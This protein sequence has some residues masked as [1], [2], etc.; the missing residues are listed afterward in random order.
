MTD[1]AQFNHVP[2]TA[3]KLVDQIGQGVIRLPDLQRPFVWSNAKVRDLIDSMYKGFPVGELMFWEHDDET[4]AHGIGGDTKEHSVRYQV[5]DGQQRLTSLYAAFTGAKVV[6]DEYEPEAVVIS[7]NPLSEEG[8]RFRVS[9]SA[10]KRSPEWLQDIRDVWAD[11]I[12]ARRKYLERLAQARGV[13]HLEYAEADKIELAIN[14]LDQIKQYPFQVIQLQETV[15]RETATD[16]FVRIN[17]QGATLSSSDLIL[18]WLSVYWEE[19]RDRLERFARDSWFSASEVEHLFGETVPNGWTPKNPYVTLR[20]GN[21]LQLAL[22]AGNH[23]TVLRDAYNVLRGRDPHT[24]KINVAQREAE[25]AKLQGGVDKALDPLSWSEWMKV[26][27][28]AGVRNKH[29]ARS[30]SAVLYGYVLWLLGRHEFGVPLEPLRD[31]MA[32]WYFMSAVS[33]RYS[34][35]SESHAQEDLNR[36]N[37]LAQTPSE[38]ARIVN[39]QIETTLT[40]S[41]WTVTLPE[42]LHTSRIN[43]AWWAYVAA[44]CVLDAEPLLC[45]KVPVSVWLDPAYNAPKGVE[46]HHLFPKH[47]LQQN[48]VTAT[49]LINQ[50]ANLALVDWH[51]NIEITDRNPAEYWPEELGK[52]TRPDGRNLSDAELKQQCAWHALPD[53][54]NTM[55]YE[56]FLEERRKLMAAVTHEGFKKLSDPSYQPVFDTATVASESVSVPGLSFDELVDGEYLSEGT[57]LVPAD[58]PDGGIT[59]TVTADGAIDLNGEVLASP[60]RAA[61]AVDKD[62]EDGWTFWAVQSGDDAAQIS[63]S[64]LREAAASRERAS[65]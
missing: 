65:E 32:R 43:S 36:F 21:T 64:E 27:V 8:D 50:V 38:F 11:P 9:N 56:Q 46:K 33:G 44:L 25:L 52:S 17:S 14:R 16:I 54:W 30:K 40:E 60:T 24:G 3:Q 55:P 1:I 18:S 51:T 22:A 34:G 47:F 45:K 2:W 48:G 62:A 23:R 61:Q 41:W 58:D 20:A 59:A 15:D 7:F 49:T 5:I 31:L 28:R 29:M 13:E 10:T 57:V 35:S 37:D 12:I 19:G 63:L 42:Q 53:G 4:H 39:T 26:L 6:R